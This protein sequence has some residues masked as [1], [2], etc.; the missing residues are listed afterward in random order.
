[1]AIGRQLVR[2]V[3]LGA[4][5]VAVACWGVCQAGKYQNDA[6]HEREVLVRP[7]L[8][9][10]P[11]RTLGWSKKS[12]LTEL[13][14][15]HWADKPLGDWKTEGKIKA[16]RALMARFLLRRELDEAN[17]YLLRQEPWGTVGSTWIGNSG[18]DYDFTLAGLTPILFLFGDEPEVL[19]P[20]ARRHLLETLLTLDG[21]EPLV[22]VPGSLGMVRDTENH[23]LMTEGSRY[24]KNRWLATHGRD[25]PRYDNVANGLEQWLLDL[26]AKL[27]SEGLYE[28]NSI[29]YEGY[30]LTALLNLEAFASPKL[31]AAA[32]DLLDHLNWKYA[33]GSFGFRRFPPFRRQYKH[34]DDTALDG[35]RHAGLMKSWMSL[36]PDEPVDVVLKDNWH[37]AIWA[38]WSPYRLPDETAR[39]MINK[40]SEYFV[41]VGHGANASPEIYSG[42]PAFLLTAGGVNRGGRSLIVARPITLMLDDDAKDL[43]EVLHLAGPG[44]S[45]RGWNNTGVWRRFAVAAGPVN[46]PDSWVVDAQSS[47]WKV[48]LRNEDV[49]VA[50]HSRNDFGIVH[51]VESTDPADVL[52]KVQDANSDAGQL[53]A[54]FQIPSGP[55]I[56]YNAKAPRNR[57]VVRQVGDRPVSR[58]FDA[59][60][61]MRLQLESEFHTA[62]LSGAAVH[63][64]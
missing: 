50:V 31:Q 28:F 25:E 15:D 29:P 60:P 22:T 4:I 2:G 51:V 13:V 44:E 55:R 42:G 1:M 16:P 41:R 14:T 45:F 63:E 56:N 37:I 18:G 32:R 19:F 52:S 48:Y 24:L 57:W 9:S 5:L 39:W 3:F 10:S 20:D 54:S 30:S 6:L 40:P 23:L 49:C 35:D 47:L 8:S 7:N 33:I 27:R 43:S 59:W 38:C 61:Q 64:R 21:G 12:E 11:A 26:I 34:A 36:Y 58:D 46:V 53:R 17:K 62:S